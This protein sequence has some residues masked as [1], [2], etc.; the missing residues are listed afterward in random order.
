[1]ISLFITFFPYLLTFYFLYRS[2]DEPVFMMG[3]PFLL[4]MGPSIF[5]EQAALFVIPFRSFESIS[6]VQDLLLLTWIVICWIIFRFRINQNAENIIRSVYPGKH[7][8]SLDYY[9]IALIFIS[10]IGFGIVLSEYY[11]L[12]NIFDKFFVLLSLFFGYF[13]IKD[14]VRHTEPKV[15][16]NFLFTI[17]IVNTIA[18]GLFFI[19]QG[20]HI[21]I[22][23]SLEEY[24]SMIVDG[25]TI[26]R[27][28]W[29]MPVLWSFSIAYL[30]A[31]KKKFTFINLTLLSVNL[32]GIY[33]SYT[34]SFLII[35]IVMIFLYFLIISYKK[36]NFYNAIKGILLIGI[37][38]AVF[39]LVLS[40]FL[41]AST[42]YFLSRFE[43][44]DEKPANA[45]SN[46]LIYRFYKTDNVISKMNP[47][48]VLF[49]Y[50]PVTDTQLPFV[51]LVNRAAADMGW[52]E[53]VFRWGYLGLAFFSLLY[54]GSII[55][56]FFLFMRTEGV[57]SKLGLVFL[58]TI[59]SQA[60][61]GFFSFT[62][63]YPS[64]FPLA[65][66]YFGILSALLIAD[67][68]HENITSI[69]HEYNES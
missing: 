12:N 24:S 45:Q 58:L 66:W 21:S 10:L 60:I 8:N 27:T 68:N 61:E 39:F 54:I 65:L 14:M 18:S 2:I 62:I 4:F 23:T 44:L 15:L 30:I 52:A 28:F 25:E 31:I 17:V 26:T 35:A 48:K 29:F 42:K 34:R 43:E 63:M 33:I 40:N 49:G 50:G 36:K 46:N 38:G 6:M 22:Y 5:I 47:G 19:H 53:V 11:I 57:I 37:A 51:Y 59:I 41:P 20:I 9:I 55:K 1:M 32:L 13:I 64:R 3:I 69:E 67:K 7:I 56:A 16:D